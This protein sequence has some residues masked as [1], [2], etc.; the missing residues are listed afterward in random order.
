VQESEHTPGGGNRRALWNARSRRFVLRLNS[1]TAIVLALA[2]LVLVNVLGQRF[3]RR[4][5]VGDTDFARLSPKTTALLSGISGSLHVVAFLEPDGSV[6]QDVKALLGAYADAA[7]ETSGLKLKLEI[8]DPNR[9]LARTRDLRRTL[10]V[11]EPN[12]VVFEFAGRTK[13][14]GESEI[15][16]HEQNVDYAKLFAGQPSVRRRLVG[17]KGE[18]LFSSA[19]HSVVRESTPSVYM[20]IG[21]GERRID[22]FSDGYGFS[23]IARTIR[24]DN[25][26]LKVVGPDGLGTLAGGSALVVAG[27]RHSFSGSEVS[28]IGSYLDRGGRMMLLL[29]P[30]VAT[31]LENILETWGV[32]YGSGRVMGPS[33]TGQELL[34][35]VRANHEVTRAFDDV[36]LMFYGAGPLETDGSAGDAADRPRVTVLAANGPGDWVE[37]DLSQDPPRFDSG[38]D[39]RGPAAVAVAIERGS[40]RDM[41]LGIK[42]TR[43]M[44]ISGS[45]F[46]SNGALKTGVSGNRDFFMSAMNWLLERDELMDIAPRPPMELRLDMSRRQVLRTY[47]VVTVFAPVLLALLG[48]VVVQQRR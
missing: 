29:D 3:Y 24:R 4:W 44:V 34:L 25:V 12:V 30:G 5:N 18:Q 35:A 15:L 37:T 14:V 6:Y 21:H 33:L 23:E 28:A 41:S 31:G 40:P 2:L 46:V 13:Y 19:I 17:F 45:D 16:E 38:V 32:R 1:A 47:L 36:V 48:F 10:G 39:R 7:R 20:A 43:I 26:Q 27:P 8:V 11:T 9:D 42:P 22:D